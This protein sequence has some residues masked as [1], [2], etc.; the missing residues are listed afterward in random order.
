MTCDAPSN[1]HTSRPVLPRAKKIDSPQLVNSM[2]CS[3]GR[4]SGVYSNAKTPFAS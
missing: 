4:D 3:S 2:W 1:N